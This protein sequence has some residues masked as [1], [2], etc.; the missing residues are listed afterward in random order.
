LTPTAS[1]Q[2]ASIGAHLAVQACVAVCARSRARRRLGLTR[3][4]PAFTAGVRDVP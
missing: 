2:E 3:H 4:L 1:D